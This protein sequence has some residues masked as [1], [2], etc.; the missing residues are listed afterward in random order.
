MKNYKDGAIENSLSKVNKYR[1]EFAHPRGMELRNK[2]NAAT[3][4]GLENI[5]NVYRCLL[6]AYREMDNY[7]IKIDGVPKMKEKQS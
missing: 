7:F 1:I 4:Q 6:Q 3:S 2:Y 5:R